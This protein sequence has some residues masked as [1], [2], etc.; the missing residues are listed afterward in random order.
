MTSTSLS[1]A[2]SAENEIVGTPAYMAPEQVE[3]GPVTPATDVY[4]LGVVLYEMVTGALPFV[5][6]TPIKT[7]IKR[8]HEPPPSPRVLVPDVDPL[9]E[10]TI[11]RCLARLPED[12]FASA[13]DVVSALEGASPSAGTTPAPTPTPFPSGSATPTVRRSGGEA[14][15]RQLTVLVAGC[16]VFESD[17]YLEL[18]SED[19]ARVLR[20]FQEQ[21]EGAVGQFGGTVVQCT[22]KGLLACYGYPVAY[23]DA[24]GRAAR[25]GRAILDAMP[26]SAEQTDRGNTLK[27]NPWV[28]IHTG[29]VVVESR[30]GVVSLVGEA[31]NVAVRLEDVAVAGQIICTEASH[32]RFQG[33]FHCVSLGRRKI[34]SVTHPV[35]LFRVDD[36]AEAGSPIDAVTPA[37]LS[38]LTG[39]D[40]EIGLLMDRWERARDG[41]GQIVLLIGEPGLGKSRLVHT[42]KQLVLGQMIEG[43]V[44]APVIEWRCS[45]HFQNTGLYPAIDFYERALAFDRKEPPQARF[46]RLRHRL[47]Q[48]DLA[49]PETLPLWA[50]LLSLPTPDRYPPLSLSPVRQREETFRTM[51]E[52]LHTRAGRKP[53]LFVVEDLHWADASTLEFLGQFLAEGQHDSILT[54]LTFR[55]E[56]KAPWPAGAHQT[57]LALTRL[58]RRQVGEMVSA[59][60]EAKELP[61]AFVDPIYERTGGVPLFVEEFTKMMQESGMLGR[62]GD[63]PHTPLPARE[64]PASLQDLLMARLDRLAG[65][66][67]VIQLAATLGREFSHELLAA[68]SEMDESTLLGEIEKLVQAEILYQKGRPPG[69]QYVFKHALLV[70]AAYNSLVK[71]KRQQFHRRIAEVLEARFAHVVGAQPELVAHHFAEAG[72]IPEAAAYW[73]KAGLRSRERSADHEAI[74]QLTTALTLLETLE[75]S[76]ER[77]DLELRVLCALAP[78]Y[79][80]VRGYAAP[81]AGPVLSRA[82]ELCE[83]VGPSTVLFGILLGTWEWRLVRGDIRSCLDLAEDGMTLA[84]GVDDPGMLMEALFMRGATKFYRAEFADARACHKSAVGFYDDRERTKL[85]VAATGHNASVTHRCYLALAL[86]HLGYADQATAMDRQT[87]E[88]AGTIGHAFSTA[89]AVDFTA[90]LYHDC[91]IG[92]EVQR[93]AEEEI[94]IAT[95]HGFELWEAL[96]VL[97]KGAGMLLQGRIDDALPLL[98]G[99][100]QAFRA[101]GAGLRIPYYLSMLGDAYTQAGRFAEARIAFDEAFATAEQ[102][103]DRFQEAELHRLAGELLL[104]ESPD[105]DDAAAAAEACFRRAIDL[106]RRQ[107]SRAWE[108]RAT[109]SLSRLWQRQGRSEEA[110]GALAAVYGR[111]TEGFATPDLVDAR[112]LLD[113]L[114]AERAPRPAGESTT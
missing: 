15:R 21:C 82:R 77:N 3:G 64:I 66:R 36:D 37:E 72:C 90:C 43:E 73:L 62:V 85:W 24:A 6:E 70:D 75:Q 89:H 102:N 93:A 44:D 50:S 101:T 49:R 42:M 100:L 91:R 28:A 29:A 48:Y 23:E 1:L 51:L 52:W 33:R 88:L 41:M 2:M 78:A 60:M 27:L 98:L 107:G 35:E 26:L 95:E 109:T 67:E 55:P 40:Q 7:A 57:S 12:R 76:E 34:K 19:Q 105:R 54:L 10:A 11:L 5:G 114:V 53:V 38:P 99:G 45:P 87:R 9:W 84:E 110:R 18:D 31:R 111:Y 46:D 20:T 83:R 108:L 65:D 8:L 68:A 103:D 113:S 112:V 56:F 79:I 97:H 74:G 14:E 86:W 104:A 80:A 59:R 16:E 63:G 22:D 30:A 92:A 39:R 94:A 58:T 47:E 96:G 13:G 106:A 69:C 25:S 17:A 81:E 71:E 61:N 32:R 4:A